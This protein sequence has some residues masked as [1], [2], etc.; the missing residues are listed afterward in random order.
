[1]NV[2]IKKSNQ[3]AI[4]DAFMLAN[5]TRMTG[6]KLIALY[7]LIQKK[8]E[9]IKTNDENLKGVKALEYKKDNFI[10]MI[11]TP[12]KKGCFYPCKLKKI[13]LTVL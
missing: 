8:G 9:P 2:N 4:H 10:A 7:K 5:D 1:M 13:V 12:F 6:N 11:H 3:W